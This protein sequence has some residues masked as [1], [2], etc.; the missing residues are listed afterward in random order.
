M[1]IGIER[2]IVSV[3]YNGYRDSSCKWNLEVKRARL[4][5]H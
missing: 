1:L 2:V 5:A 4:G 3:R